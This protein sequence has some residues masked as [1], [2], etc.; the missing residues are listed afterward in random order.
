MHLYNATSNHEL[1]LF[2]FDLEFN[3]YSI[4]KEIGPVSLNFEVPMYNPSG[5]Q[6]VQFFILLIE[7][8]LR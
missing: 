7:S 5:L 2:S 8:V 4:R 3:F 6:V 1:L